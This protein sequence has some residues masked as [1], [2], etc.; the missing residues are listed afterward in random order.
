MYRT[1]VVSTLR[2]DP[3]KLR[4][5]TR[6]GEVNTKRVCGDVDELLR[7]SDVHQKFLSIV[8]SF[9]VKLTE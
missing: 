6:V 2:L 8:L 3:N 4:F 1:F 5:Q 9:G 7:K